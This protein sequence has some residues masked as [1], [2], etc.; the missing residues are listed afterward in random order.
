[1]DRVPTWPPQG[2][3]GAGQSDYIAV[4]DILKPGG[5]TT[6]RQSFLVEGGFDERDNVASAVEDFQ[7]GQ[8]ALLAKASR[9][10]PVMPSSSVAQL[11]QRSSFGSGDL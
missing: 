2:S 5:R 11:D 6:A 3:S 4:E 10:S 7:P 1:M 9:A 8:Q